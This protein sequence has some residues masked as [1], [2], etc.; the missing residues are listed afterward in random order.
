MIMASRKREEPPKIVGD[1]PPMHILTYISPFVKGLTVILYVARAERRYVRR[2]VIS[3][4]EFPPAY[5]SMHLDVDTVETVP[6]TIRHTHTCTWI[7]TRR[8]RARCILDRV[9]YKR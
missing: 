6:R 2:L 7:S 9:L 1:S 5:S 4:Y 3:K 8:T